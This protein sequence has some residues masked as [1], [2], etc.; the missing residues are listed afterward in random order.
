MN[1]DIFIEKLR[2]R[3]RKTP[4]SP[5]FLSL[6]EELQK[7]DAHEEAIAVLKSGIEQS[8]SFVAAKLTLGRWLFKEE[9]LDEAKKAFY[10]IIEH[11]P[12]DRFAA[13]YLNEIE[14]RLSSG[15]DDVRRRTIDRLNIFREAIHKRFETGSPDVG[16]TKEG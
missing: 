9:K 15:K 3:V 6:A 16:R 8:P 7:R 2:E 4:G 13:L 11:A 1:A 10:S 12:S 14:D 5:L